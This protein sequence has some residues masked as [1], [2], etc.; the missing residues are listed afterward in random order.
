MIEYLRRA[1]FGLGLG[2]ALV[3]L[4]LP[5]MASGSEDLK[6]AKV[7][8]SEGE[9]AAAMNFF[10]LAITDG[11]LT[12]GQ[13]SVAY[14]LRGVSRGKLN[15]HRLAQMDHKKAVL[16]NPNN[17]EAWSS[18]CYQHGANSKQFDTA[19]QACDTALGLDPKHAPSY[20]LRAVVWH[21]LAQLD[22]AEGDFA[23]SIQL[24]PNNW[25]VYFNRGM[26][27]HNIQEPVKAKN[28]FAKAYQLASK[29]E[30][31]GITADPVFKAY[32]ITR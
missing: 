5:A 32:G 13:L 28:S 26:F 14:H 12:T 22:R 25:G 6:F 2:L 3:I 21:G 7:L 29:W 15:K 18:L 16:L 9:W 30:R 27:Y 20:A 11:A 31:H 1:R 8:L 23:Q 10:G 24:A 19:M 17:V 4:P